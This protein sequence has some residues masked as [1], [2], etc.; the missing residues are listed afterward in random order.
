[1]KKNPY[2]AFR[3]QLQIDQSTAA[4]FHEVGGIRVEKETET[5]REGGVNTGEYKLPRGTTFSDVTLKRGYIDDTLWTWHQQVVNGKFKRKTCT[6]VLLDESGGAAARWNLVRAFPTVWEG[7]TFNA[8]SSEI[9][10][11]ALTLAHEGI[12]R[13]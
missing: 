3:F 6:I 2:G 4:G 7:P 11:E 13:T 5:V 1:M 12:N 10:T 9:A 8:H